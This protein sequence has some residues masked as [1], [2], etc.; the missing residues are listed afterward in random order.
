LVYTKNTSR[1]QEE[2][3]M[4]NWYSRAT[5]NFRKLDDAW[6]NNFL[7]FSW[8]IWSISTTVLA[9]C[10]TRLPTL[11]PLWHSQPWGKGQLASKESLLLLVVGHLLILTVN[12]I[13]S[14]K[15]DDQKEE[16][17]LRI[18]SG[19]TMLLQ[20]LYA[21]ETFILVAR[22]VASPLISF[23]L[24]SKTALPAIVAWLITYL[25]TPVIIRISKKYSVITD[26]QKNHHPAMLLKQTTP[27][28]GA[29][30]VV[31]GI[32]FTCVIF[33]PLGKK[34]IGIYLG[35]FIAMLV[36]I[37]D[38]K[39]D[40]NPYVR[41][42]VLMPLAVIVTIGFGL[43][44]AYLTNPWGGVINLTQ[45]QI[46]FQLWGSHTFLILANLVSFLWMLWVMNMLSWSNGVDGQFPGII[47]I[48]S[49]TLGILS[50]RFDQANPEQV[51]AAVLAF[52]TLGACL[53]IIKYTWHPCKILLGFGT[54]A[55]G[56]ILAAI[57]IFS[58]GKVATA[59]LI[60]FIPTVDALYT[61]AR[62]LKQGKSPVWGDRQHF[63]HKLL[64]LGLTQTQVSLV[65]WG[66]TALL[67]GGV[68][69]SSG[70]V[71]VLTALTSL[72][73]FASILI[74]SQRKAKILPIKPKEPA[75]E[76]PKEN[77][78]ASGRSSEF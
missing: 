65:Y 13:V 23:G 48:S 5:Y 67:A 43:G 46:T 70:K 21:G 63:H 57:S 19:I 17:T 32:I 78:T 66:V 8:L 58:T 47:A 6:G 3:T 59:T 64:D 39:F 76:D 61:I 29:V 62:R 26:P 52:A 1:M 30:G 2:L 53:G 33:L 69:A 7:F 25:A 40:L 27:R 54:T 35:A 20:L 51:Q 75:E 42:L 72:G 4:K 74:F 50:L 77:N 12:Q 15:L 44:T 71:K 14:K 73:L 49:L 11:I 9:I 37:L 16:I 38:D 34:L 36:G 45:P 41:L 18:I 24:L 56:L 55:I 31:L 28:M 68:L 10:W 22:T 60:L